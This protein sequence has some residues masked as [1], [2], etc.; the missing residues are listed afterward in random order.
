VAFPTTDDPC[1]TP[2]DPAYSYADCD[3]ELVVPAGDAYTVVD[4]FSTFGD[5]SLDSCSVYLTDPAYTVV[6]E[7]TTGCCECP[8]V[9]SG[10]TELHAAV[11]SDGACGWSGTIVLTLENP[12]L[13]PKDTACWKGTIV[14]TNG[15]TLLVAFCCNC[16]GVAR[17]EVSV[18]GP[19][20]CPEGCCTVDGTC[21]PLQVTGVFCCHWIQGFGGGTIDCGTCCV[22]VVV[23]L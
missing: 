16:D 14:G 8:C 17:L 13:A 21:V 15:C 1:P 23:T 18:N 10:T 7:Y 5:A 12:R 2:T 19:S 9:P 22:T 11:S 3:G 6:D 4:E 20:L